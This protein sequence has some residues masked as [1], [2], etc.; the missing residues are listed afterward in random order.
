VAAGAALVACVPFVPSTLVHAARPAAERSAK[1]SAAAP[2]E[3]VL[4]VPDVCRFAYVFAKGALQDAG[5]AW[6][7]TG[8]VEGYAGN[9]VVTQYPA[10]GTLVVDTGAPLIELQLE[11]G[12][13]YM[14]RG[15]PEGGAPYPATLLS[16]HTLGDSRLAAVLSRARTAPVLDR[17]E[18][19]ASPVQAQPHGL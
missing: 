3:P 4:V 11:R 12:S 15:R 9:R 2:A 19:G 1:Q 6:Q 18:R 17:C 16:I 10:P 14:P 5:F 8:P 13:G 7:V